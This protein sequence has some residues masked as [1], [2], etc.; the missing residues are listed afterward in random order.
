MVLLP[1]TTLDGAIKVA[2]SIRRRIEVHHLAFPRNWQVPLTVSLGVASRQDR[3][4]PVSLFER[5]DRA[6]YQAKHRGRNQVVHENCL[7]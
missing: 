7:S 5:A 4:D 2:E 3:D 1:D 6:L